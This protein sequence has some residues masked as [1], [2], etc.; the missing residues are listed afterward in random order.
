[1]SRL[2]STVFA[3]CAVS[4]VLA[5][6]TLVAAQNYPTKQIRMIV[7]FAGGGASDA[8]ARILA[9]K[10]G[11]QLG[12]RLLVD[13]R[14]GAGG[15]IGT[16]MGAKAEASGHTL[17]FSTSGP[18]AVN[19]WLYPD[20]PYDPERDLEP[21]SLVATLPNVLVVSP[22]LAVSNTME[23]IK[24]AKEHPGDTFYASIGNGS[25]QH[26][27]GVLFETVTG[28][29][30][31]HVPYKVAG[32]FVVDLMSGDIQSS[33][34]L[35]PNVLSQLKTGKI[36]SI[37]VMSKE[38]SK[39]LPDVP[40]MAEQGVPNLES[41]AWFGLLAPKGTPKPI[42]E[43]LHGEVVK[44]VND[45]EVR[46]RLLEIGADPASS[47]PS[48]FKALMAEESLKWRDLIKSMNIKAD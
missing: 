24:Y 28:V 32:Q 4:A 36:R 17:V 25:S 11:I 16:D 47:S 13:N 45:P 48:E 21:I 40:T 26:L 41:A 20:L 42:I 34:Q 8:V 9:D 14:P 31:Q 6:C 3:V 35:I 1:M 46:T 10:L 37:A 44:A 43:R 27:A 33:F 30:L 19:R 5:L 2:R 39:T 29:R 22:K 15:N 38:R 23:F 12:N 7:P 18:L